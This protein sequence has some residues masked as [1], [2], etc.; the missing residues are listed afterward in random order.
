L[1]EPEGAA[2][3]SRAYEPPVGETET[4]LAE[5]WARALGV[6]QVGRHDN[7]FELGGHSLLAV[8][9]VER[10]RTLGF[11]TDVRTLFEAPTVA[12]FAAAFGTSAAVVEVP[13]NLIPS[14]PTEDPDGD[15]GEVE[16]EL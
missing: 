14:T 11:E 10:L 8:T 5:V 4:L 13:P 12:Q 7:F 3:A 6:E 9:L 1:P 16:I 15:S 2:Y